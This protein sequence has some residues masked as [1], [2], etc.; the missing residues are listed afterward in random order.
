RRRQRLLQRR[1]LGR[2]EGCGALRPA[3]V[4][5][6]RGRRASDH[7]RKPCLLLGPARQ[8]PLK[9]ERKVGDYF[10]PYEIVKSLASGGMGEVF[11]AR[12]TG[13]EGFKKLLVI[14]TLL[15]EHSAD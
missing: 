15:T 3:R 12:M 5:P 1:P 13:P 9:Y 11:L 6:Q 2:L 8:P 14:K 4:L 7:I 10:G